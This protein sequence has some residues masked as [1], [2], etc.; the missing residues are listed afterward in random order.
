MIFP[1]VITALAIVVGVTVA[2]MFA[3]SVDELRQD[4][5][6]LEADIEKCARRMVD[7]QHENRLMAI[8]LEMEREEN[9]QLRRSLQDVSS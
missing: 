8:T 5:A 9:A 3:P 4:I 2:K 6:A 1:I 7:L